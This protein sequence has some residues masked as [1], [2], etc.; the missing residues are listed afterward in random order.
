MLDVEGGP[1]VKEVE[2]DDDLVMLVPAN[3]TCS[4]LDD[5]R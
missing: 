4:L 1:E 5:G 3:W 2:L